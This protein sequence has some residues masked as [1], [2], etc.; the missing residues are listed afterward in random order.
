MMAVLVASILKLLPDYY[1]YYYY[2]EIILR[3]R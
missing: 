1:Y 3:K 2:Y